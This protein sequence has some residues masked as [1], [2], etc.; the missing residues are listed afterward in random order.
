MALLVNVLPEAETTALWDSAKYQADCS[1][2]FFV[3]PLSLQI[4]VYFKETHYYESPKIKTR[5]D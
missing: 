1:D 3:L 4:P 5:P 2:G